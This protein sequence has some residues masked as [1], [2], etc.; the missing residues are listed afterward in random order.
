MGSSELSLRR[1]APLARSTNV[2]VPGAVG[3]KV[4]MYCKRVSLSLSLS[5]RL[6]KVDIV[7]G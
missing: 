3:S 5:L 6:I 4:C 7:Q 2:A 1:T